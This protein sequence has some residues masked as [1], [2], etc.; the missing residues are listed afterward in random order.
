MADFNKAFDKMIANE[1][2]YV[3]H[4]VKGD[5]GGRTYAGIAENY[6]PD[7]L[8]WEYLDG[9]IGIDH[10]SMESFVRGFYRTKFW[11]KVCGDKIADQEVADTLFDFAVNTGHSTAIK[12]AQG[13]VNSVPD[14]IIGPKTL[15]KLNRMRRDEFITRYALAKIGRYARIVN[16]DRSQ[17]KFLLG[18]INRTLKMLNN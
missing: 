2:G 5:S 14:G 10:K 11:D 4:K 3:L 8:G 12:I 16:R 6:H 18:W 15:S 1:G 13:V 7:W 9:N 17:S